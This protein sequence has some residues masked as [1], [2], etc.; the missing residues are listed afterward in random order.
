MLAV[1]FAD[2]SIKIFNLAKKVQKPLEIKDIK[3]KTR[4]LLFDNES[5]LY[6]CGAD[7][8]IRKI[9]PSTE[10]LSSVFCDLLKRN[11]TSTEWS[12]NISETIPYEKTCKNK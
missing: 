2:K 3:S 7:H 8:F 9:E 11:L 10:K 1:A 12:Q 6:V 5:K 4:Y